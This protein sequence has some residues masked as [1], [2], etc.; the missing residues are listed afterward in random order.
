MSQSTMYPPFVMNARE[1]AA[2]LGISPRT[3]QA[4]QARG[5]IT[6]KQLGSK[7]GFLREDLEEWARDQPEWETRVWNP[8][9]KK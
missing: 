1:A 5:D 3:L 4:L 8:E 7:R 2:Y 9:A 6:P